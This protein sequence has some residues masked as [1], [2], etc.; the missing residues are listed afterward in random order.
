MPAAPARR[1]LRLG[2]AARLS[3]DCRISPD[4]RSFSHFVH[5]TRLANRDL[6]ECADQTKEDL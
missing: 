2:A 4:G 1:K 6:L 3:T 5:A